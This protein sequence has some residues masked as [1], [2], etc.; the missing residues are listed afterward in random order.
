MAI[1][2]MS[3]EQ[4]RMALKELEQAI[5]NHNQWAE[6]IFSALICRLPP[7]QRDTRADAHHM[8]RFGQWF[9]QVG[10]TALKDHPGFAEI[11]HEHE[12]MHQYAA[13][14]LRSSIEGVPISITDLDLFVNARKRLHLE[15]AT[16]QHE[17]EVALFNLDPLTGTPSRT[18]MLSTL[19]EQ[20]EFARRERA[21]AVVMMDLDHFKSVND[22]YGHPAG[23]QVLIGFARH[24]MAHLRPYDKFFRYGGEEFLICLPDTDLHTAGSVIDR[25]RQELATLSFEAQDKSRFQVTGS[26]GMCLLDP[27]M[28]VE[29]SIERADKALYVAKESGRNRVV[30]WDASMGLSG[31][32]G[33]LA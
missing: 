24:I 14:L 9:Y 11:G 12:R 3:D 5:Y 17:F 30:H 25:L 18:G 15:I 16:V 8:C 33:K 6:A 7:D 13:D 10:N 1:P 23:D 19:R 21:C 27:D 32:P 29:Q 31:G 2:N 26:F 28:P 4:M 20:L 22:K